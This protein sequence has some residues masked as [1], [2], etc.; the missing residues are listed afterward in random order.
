MNSNFLIKSIGVISDRPVATLW[1]FMSEGDLKS[2]LG[3][4][5]SAPSESVSSVLLFD[6]FLQYNNK[7]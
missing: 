3:E 7:I 5:S 4:M 2:V 1:E 6:K